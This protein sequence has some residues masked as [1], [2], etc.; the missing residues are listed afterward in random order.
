MESGGGGFFPFGGGDPEELLGALREFARP[1][2]RL[3]CRYGAHHT[4]RQMVIG[5]TDVRQRKSWIE[6]ERLFETF[7]TSLRRLRRE[8]PLQRSISKIRLVGR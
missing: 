2:H 1:W 3:L 4:E 7:A 8:L 6:P 5:Q